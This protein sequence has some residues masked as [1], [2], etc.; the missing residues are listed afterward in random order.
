MD[1]KRSRS[2]KNA[3]HKIHETF[4]DVLFTFRIPSEELSRRA[5]Q[6]PKDMVVCKHKWGCLRCHILQKSENDIIEYRIH[7][8]VEEDD[9]QKLS[10][11]YLEK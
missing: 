4:N 9:P 1:G 7:K 6:Q 3:V 11:K 8:E 10:G 2:C 5:K